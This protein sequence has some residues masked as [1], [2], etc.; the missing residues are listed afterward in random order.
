MYLYLKIKFLINLKEEKKYVKLNTDD[1][2]IV[3]Q[4]VDYL[5]IEM[6]IINNALYN[7]MQFEKI[8]PDMLVT[9]DLGIP[10][11]VVPTEKLPLLLA[12]E[13]IE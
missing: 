8:T 3:K 9:V 5:I 11:V 6:K 10:A 4:A 12:Q 2:K 1:F 13:K 7:K